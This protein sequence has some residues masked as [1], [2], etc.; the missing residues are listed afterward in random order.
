LVIALQYR[1]EVEGAPLR[2]YSARGTNM[3]MAHE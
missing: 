2:A 3:F 1:D